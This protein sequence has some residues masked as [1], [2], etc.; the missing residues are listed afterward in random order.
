MPT[1]ATWLRAH[2]R[3]IPDFPSPG[4]VFKDI[5]PLLADVDAFRFA[6]DAIADSWAGADVSHVAGIEARGFLLA[7]PVAYRLGASLLPIRKPGKLPWEV[8][9]QAYELEYGVDAVQAHRDAAQPGD[10][11]LVVDD[12]LATGGTAAAACTLLGALGA[13]VVGVHVLLELAFLHGRATL[14]E[15]D[16]RSLLVEA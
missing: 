10:H 11:V 6:V 1:D 12:V 13:E 15:R 9:E 2:L 7:A 5:T 14:G 3:D 16:V 4:V 8:V